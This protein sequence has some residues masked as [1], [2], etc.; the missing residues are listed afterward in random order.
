MQVGYPARWLLVGIAVFAVGLAPQAGWAA[1]KTKGK[2]QSVKFQT[3]DGV[4]LEGQFYPSAKGPDA[5]VVLMLHELGGKMT[6]KNWQELAEALQANNFAVLMFD[7]RGHG[8]SIQVDEEFWKN[9]INQ[10]GVKGFNATKPRDSITS[11]DFLD[12]SYCLNFLNDI[13]AAKVYLDTLNDQNK[14]NSANLILLGAK[15]GATLGSLWLR[16]E[17][18]RYPVS[19]AGIDPRSPAGKDVVGAVW[20]TITSRLGERGPSVALSTTLQFNKKQK[21]PMAFLYADKDHAGRKVANAVLNMLNPMK[22]GKRD[23]KLFIAGKMVKDAQNAKGR[24]LLA[25]DD[26]T[27]AI[28][29]WLNDLI[30]KKKMNAWGK[31][32]FKGSA[33]VWQFP[34]YPRA[35][36]AKL[37]GEKTLAYIPPTPPWLVGVG[38]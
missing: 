25:V 16:E 4:W 38:R 24:D 10:R 2:F 7:F 15:E 19:A 29:G 11:R 31:Q 17:W 34:G 9:P 37:R 35:Q 8:K 27:K 33:Y 3:V 20:L 12:R 1:D 18:Y 30:D 26:S 5:P 14:V 32:D 28:I 6:L 23:P 22:H 36:T 13:S 21:V